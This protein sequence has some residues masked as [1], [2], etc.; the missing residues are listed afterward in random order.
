MTQCPLPPPLLLCSPSAAGLNILAFLGPCHSTATLLLFCSLS[1]AALN[2]SDL[3]ILLDFNDKLCIALQ[4]STESI[5]AMPKQP[6]Q[7]VLAVS[8]SCKKLCTAWAVSARCP[9]HLIAMTRSLFTR[10][11]EHLACVS[12]ESCVLLS[13]GMATLCRAPYVALVVIVCGG[14]GSAGRALVAVC[15]W[16]RCGVL[17]VVVVIVIMACVAK[18]WR[19]PQLI[20]V[21]L[22]PPQTQSRRDERLQEQQWEAQARRGFRG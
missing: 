6:Q 19:R 1:R 9:L 3:L 15:W 16:W 12:A 4:E 8:L 14:S 21:A 11:R 2:F 7:K 20:F 22:T 10:T 13:W 17:M 18:K 5:Y